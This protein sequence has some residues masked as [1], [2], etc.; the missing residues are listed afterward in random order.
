MRRKKDIRQRPAHFRAFVISPSGLIPVN[1][2]HCWA[3]P[4]HRTLICRVRHSDDTR[5]DIEPATV[6]MQLELLH[7][8]TLLLVA[9]NPARS[10][11]SFASVTGHLAAAALVWRKKTPVSHARK[12]A[13]SSFICCLPQT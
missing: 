9:S 5:R 7:A 13:G 10:C 6:L 2:E 4:L 3:H 8:D 12:M 1:I 11:A